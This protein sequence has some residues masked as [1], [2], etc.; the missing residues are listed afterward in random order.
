MAAWK[1]IWNTKRNKSGIHH[2]VRHSDIG[3]FSAVIC[4]DK[5]VIREVVRP[6]VL[7]NTLKS[8]AICGVLLQNVTSRDPCVLVSVCFLLLV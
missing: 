8:G 3:M 1:N 5:L 2:Q 6:Y 4:S 7:T